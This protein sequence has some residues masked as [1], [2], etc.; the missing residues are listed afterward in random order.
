MKIQI[1]DQITLEVATRIAS[2]K[3]SSVWSGHAQ[4]TK[5]SKMKLKATE[6]PPVKKTKV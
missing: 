5:I 4:L 1:I 3:F 2:N 6:A